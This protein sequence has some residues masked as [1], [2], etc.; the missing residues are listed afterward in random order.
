MRIKFSS[1]SAVVSAVSA[2]VVVDVVVGLDEDVVGVL[3]GGPSK[4][5]S[6]SSFLIV[7]S[8]SLPDSVIS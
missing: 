2:D 7:H 4:Y 3:V 5:S 8:I 1:V 6:F